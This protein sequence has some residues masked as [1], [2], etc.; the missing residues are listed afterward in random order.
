MWRSLKRMAFWALLIAAFAIALVT[1]ISDHKDDYGSLVLPPG[2]TVHLPKGETEV[3][4]EE[5]QGGP[6]SAGSELSSPLTF[7]VVAVGGGAPLT[8]SGS[9]PGASGVETERSEDVIERGAVAQ[10]DV[11]AEGDYTVTGGTK[12]G[13]PGVISFGVDPVDAVMNKWRLFAVLLGGALLI[14]LLPTP[15]TRRNP[16]TAWAAGDYS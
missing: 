5:Q 8:T 1:A 11:P 2:G 9:A 15:R 6:T 7:T 10:L 3:F 16:D 4:Y 14:S 13:A 12:S